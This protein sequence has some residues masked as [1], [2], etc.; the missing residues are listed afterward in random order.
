MTSTRLPG[1]V[2]ADLGGQPM[3]GYLLDRVRRADSL[4]TIM[5][6]TTTNVK[7]DAIVQLCELENVSVFRGSEV[8]VLGRFAGAASQCGARTV[9]RLT[10][11]CPLH[12]P[13]VINA[14][15]QKYE[16]GNWDYLSN[17]LRRTYPDGLDVEVFSAS[18]LTEAETNAVHP[19]CREHVTPY[20]S[21]SRPE[22][23]RGDF[24]RGD[25]TFEANF[26]H[27]RWTVDREVDLRRVRNLVDRLPVEHGWLD[28]LSIATRQPDLLGATFS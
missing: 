26:G 9:V 24:R 3:L 5:V 11:D 13:A 12:D 25:L 8:D 7:D 10:A 2:L 4:D 6:A 20:I 15:V 22:F 23:G 18:A 1:K 21:G 19:Y 28:A 14:A 16:D 17:T 27:I